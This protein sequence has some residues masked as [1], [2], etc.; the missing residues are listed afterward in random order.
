MKNNFHWTGKL[1][2][3]AQFIRGRETERNQETAEE[4]CFYL[5]VAEYFWGS[6]LAD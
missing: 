5:Y 3:Y 1:L 2:P 6:W 4:F